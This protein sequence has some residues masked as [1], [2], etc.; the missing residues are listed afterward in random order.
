MDSR[1][2]ARC[3]G[4]WCGVILTL[5]L[6]ELNSSLSLLIVALVAGYSFPLIKHRSLW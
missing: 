5:P 1:R 3:E 6:V 2:R 4:C